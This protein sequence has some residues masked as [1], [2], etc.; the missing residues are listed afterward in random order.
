M[1]SNLDMDLA[2]FL[3]EETAPTPPPRQTVPT[4]DP[5][6]F[7]DGMAE[8]KPKGKGKEYPLLPD[9][10]GRAAKMAAR[11][12]D[13]AGAKEQLDTNNKLL[14][15]LVLPFWIKHWHG[16]TDFESG[17]KVQTDT[18]AAVLVI[19]QSRV[20]KMEGEK[21]L[22]PVR[23]LFRRND[24]DLVPDLFHWGFSIKIDGNEIPPEVAP[25]LVKELKELFAKHGAN[26]ALTTEK[27]YKPYPSFF[28]QRH[29][30][31]TPEQNLAINN[32]IPIV[33]QVKT[34]GVS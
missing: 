19:C 4:T 3:G 32:A 15:E 26:K 29:V 33:T 1:I 11:S 10:D 16:K 27:E 30:L 23:S 2:A 20:K 7:L 31:F 25:A 5:L 8:A 24:R 13:L 18:G 6:A 17:V 21:A 34:K 9:P 12:I 22:D 14:A 28:T